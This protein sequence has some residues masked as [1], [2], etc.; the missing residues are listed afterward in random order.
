MEVPDLAHVRRFAPQQFVKGLRGRL[1]KIHN[2]VLFFGDSCA[3]NT[4]LLF[5]QCQRF[6]QLLFLRQQR[7]VNH[8]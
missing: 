6:L 1:P 3:S 7:V 2:A 8:H 5:K 4:R